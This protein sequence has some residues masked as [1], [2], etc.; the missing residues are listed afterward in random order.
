MSGRY[1]LQQKEFV[2]RVT[3]Y[4]I[5][6][7]VTAIVLPIR[8][9]AAPTRSPLDGTLQVIPYEGKQPRPEVCTHGEVKL[10]DDYF[11]DR[12]CRQRESY[13]QLS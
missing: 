8:I 13:M 4:Y 2:A 5:S 9:R 6:P 7:K 12:H 1:L 11:R 10:E 3:E